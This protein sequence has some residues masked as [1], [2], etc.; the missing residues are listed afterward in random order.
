MNCQFRN[1]RIVNVATFCSIILLQISEKILK[2]NNV[3]IKYNE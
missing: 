3:F 2:I 1:R